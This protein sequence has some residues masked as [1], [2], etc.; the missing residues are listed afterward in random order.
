MN[1][2]QSVTTCMHKYATFGGRASRSEYWWFAG[3][4]ILVLQVAEPVG[5]FAWNVSVASQQEINNSL[6][7][8][9]YG[10]YVWYGAA[11][12]LVLPYIAVSFRRL[13]DTGRSGWW[14]WMPPGM[15]TLVEFLVRPERGIMFL[16]VGILFLLGSLA[17]MIY[18][19]VLPGDADANR[20]GEPPIAG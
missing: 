6:V 13:H 12:V 3:L 17:V 7:A 8:E 11:L 1:F 9:M 20:F 15:V 10:E 19:L 5:K 2:Q 4:N 16:I 18:W 14:F